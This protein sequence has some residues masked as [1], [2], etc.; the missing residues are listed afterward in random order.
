[1]QPCPFSS[2]IGEQRLFAA[3]HVHELRTDWSLSAHR[4]WNKNEGRPVVQS[5]TSQEVK[6]LWDRGE[7]FLLVNTLPAEKFAETRIPGAVNI[8]E[9]EEDFPGRVLQKA[10]SKEKAIVVYCA[11]AKC[12]SSNK[13]MQKL[14]DAGFEDVWE[15][16]EGAEGW[17]AFM[18]KK[19]STAGRRVM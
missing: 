11:S 4:V 5:I 13:A 7:D 18:A 6:H 2:R 3:A 9:S 14:L 8:P 10:G 16:V 19:R 1:L 12:D 15:F 17:R